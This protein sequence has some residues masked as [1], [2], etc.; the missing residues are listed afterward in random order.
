[1]PCSSRSHPTASTSASDAEESVAAA[2]FGS[3]VNRL[4]SLETTRARSRRGMPTLARRTTRREERRDR[5]TQINAAD[6]SPWKTAAGRT[7]GRSDSREATTRE[8]ASG[9]RYISACAPF[10]HLAPRMRRRWTATSLAP[11]AVHTALTWREGGA[12][13][14]GRE[15]AWGEALL[16]GRKGMGW[17][18]RARRRGLEAV[19]SRTASSQSSSMAAKEEERWRMPSTPQTP[20]CLA[21][22]SRACSLYLSISSPAPQ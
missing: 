9:S 11:A 10:C 5:S 21:S 2:T 1:M 16:N 8:T 3:T 6:G 4:G 15:G 22:S 12:R 17:H 13:G 20:Y 7:P 14:R 19:A 18:A